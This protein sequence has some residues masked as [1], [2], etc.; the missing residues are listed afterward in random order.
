MHAC[1]LYQFL[2][3][4]AESLAN[5]SNYW[6]TSRL[7]P[8]LVYTRASTLVP[9]DQV[10]PWVQEVKATFDSIF[11]YNHRRGKELRDTYALH[12]QRIM[13][14]RRERREKIERY[15]RALEEEAI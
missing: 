9:E 12:Y 4:T 10:S 5:G 6:L 8:N 14:K 11:E 2:S 3:L 7:F 1:F 15:H 13:A